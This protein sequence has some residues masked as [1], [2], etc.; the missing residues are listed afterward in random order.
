[1]R[2]ALIGITDALDN[3]EVAGIPEGLQGLQ[4]GMQSQARIQRQNLV[5]RNSQGWPHLLIQ[6]VGKRNDRAQAIVAAGH[7][8]DY[9]GVVGCDL[10][11]A[12]TILCQRHSRCYSATED[13][14]HDHTCGNRQHA[15]FHHCSAREFHMFTSITQIAQD[16]GD[17]PSLRGGGSEA[18]LACA[19][20]SRSNEFDQFSWYSGE[21]ISKY[22]APRT[23]LSSNT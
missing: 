16:G 19:L 14:R 11:K 15:I 2:E 4:I 22:S 9:Q 1:M 18:M 7:L 6:R 20:A 21:A 12:G 5:V 3:R 23:R 10:R 17:A 13:G 8:H